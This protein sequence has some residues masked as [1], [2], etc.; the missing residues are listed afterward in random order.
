MEDLLIAYY[1]IAIMIGFI[2]LGIAGFWL[3]RTKDITPLWFCII[4]ALFT[5]FMILF[6]LRKYFYLNVEGYSTPTWYLFI[7]VSQSLDFAIIIATLYSIFEVYKLPYKKPVMWV[8]LFISL[9]AIGLT[10]F[11]FGKNLRQNS[12]SLQF[13]TEN[14]VVAL[15]YMSIFTTV[16]V[17]GYGFIRRIWHSKGRNF[18]VG[19]LMFATVGYV[20][21]LINSFSSWFD[22]SLSISKE[23]GGFLFSSVPY[24]LYG[25]FLIHYFV[26]QPL[27]TALEKQEISAGFVSRY[28][29]T[30]REREIILK[31]VQG[32]SNADIA[33][34]L[35]I[36][37]ATVKAH[38][39]NI[40]KKVEVGGRF[41]LLAKVR[42]DQ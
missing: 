9:I 42:S 6:V 40:Y 13:G 32:K 7:G 26:S 5:L 27:P 23:T 25:I 28:G 12:G 2:A 1:L 33:N 38:L 19:L 15:W 37:L 35:F 18:I 3:A 14:R 20:E 10:I 30:E 39:Y 24:A 22:V 11:S 16:L 21:V 4:Y 36:S 29:I 41:D 17:L 31:V 8:Y 34:E